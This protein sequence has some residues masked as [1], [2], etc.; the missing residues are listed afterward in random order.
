MSD[1]QWADSAVLLAR[2]EQRG[3]ETRQEEWRQVSVV[4]HLFEAVADYH[5]KSVCVKKKW[6]SWKVSVTLTWMRSGPNVC[7]SPG[8][9]LHSTRCTTNQDQFIKFHSNFSQPLLHHRG[10]GLRRGA[11]TFRLN[12]Q[13]S[14]VTQNRSK[15]TWQK[16]HVRQR[17]FFFAVTVTSPSPIHCEKFFARNLTVSLKLEDWTEMIQFMCHKTNRGED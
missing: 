5:S 4:E 6:F 13:M 7:F 3:R 15:T 9:L 10:L 1:K 2:W 16:Q 12:V 8:K 17:T 14:S 11:P